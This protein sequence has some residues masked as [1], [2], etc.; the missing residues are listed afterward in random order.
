MC[1]PLI[2][3][4]YACTTALGIEWSTLSISSCMGMDSG[5][6]S[7]SLPNSTLSDVVEV[8]VQQGDHLQQLRPPDTLDTSATSDAVTVGPLSAVMGIVRLA[9]R[10]CSLVNSYR[11][12]LTI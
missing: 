10:L 7:C 4:L 3:E 9:I 11:S 1:N 5:N 8:S 2:I 6:Y 12:M